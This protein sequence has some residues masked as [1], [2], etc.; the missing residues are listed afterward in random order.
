MKNAQLRFGLCALALGFALIGC[1]KDPQSVNVSVMTYNVAGL[2]EP[3]SGSKPATYTSTI[4][5]LMNVVD[6]VHVQED[7]HYHDS[8]LLTDRHTYQTPFMGDAFYGDGLNTFSLFPYQNFSRTKW[9]D[10]ADADCFTPK[11]FSYSQIEVAPD[12]WIDFYNVHMNAKTYEEASVARQK[13]TK[14]L[15]AYIKEH[16][17]GRPVI[18]MGDMNSRYTRTA[19]SIRYV[20]DLGFSDPWIEL[21]RNGQLPPQDDNSL[22]NCGTDGSARTQIDCEKVDKIFYRGND[23]VEIEPILYQLDDI[24]YYFHNNDTLPLSDHWPLFTVFRITKRN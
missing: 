2:P 22:V 24:Q 8:L 21:V 20:L 10:C 13:N 18:V 7:F 3:I 19:D 4:G 15:C 9:T 23:K 1:K 6:I 14:Q 16:S 5:R 12:L 11:G 17:A